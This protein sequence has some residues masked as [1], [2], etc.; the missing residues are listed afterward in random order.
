MA[1]D[2]YV[3]NMMQV[4]SVRV[5]STVTRVLLLSVPYVA[6]PGIVFFTVL[7]LSLGLPSVS[8]RRVLLCKNSLLR[9]VSSKYCRY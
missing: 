1:S 8:K 6:M 2:G 7:F 4:R 9:V 3:A 5:V